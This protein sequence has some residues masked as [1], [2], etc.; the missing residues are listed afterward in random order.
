M[1]EDTVDEL[2]GHLRGALRAVVEC[3]NRREDRG[4]CFRRQ[5]HVTQM[6]AIEGRFAYAKNEWATL[7]EADI[8]GAMNQVAG[9]T[10]CDGSERAHGAGQN[11]HR[12]AR[13]TSAGNAGTDIRLAVQAKFAA[14]LSEEFLREIVAAAELKFL[15]KD[16]QGAIG[17][18]EV[19]ARDAIVGGERAQHLCGIDAA[20]RS[21]DRERN[22]ESVRVGLLHRTDYRLA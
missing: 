17:G 12:A 4:S 20:A 11:N 16:A 3:G 6:N 15:C 7:L 2:A 5:L 10:V 14:G 19:N 13:V 21:G 8:G 1:C 22:S 18:D 9:E